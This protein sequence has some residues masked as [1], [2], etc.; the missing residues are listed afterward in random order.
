M[1]EELASYKNH[2][3][4]LEVKSMKSETINDLVTS[5]YQQRQ[6]KRCK[7]ACPDVAKCE[8]STYFRDHAALAYGFIC[9][10][11]LIKDMCSDVPLVKW[12]NINSL[13]E[14]LRNPWQAQRAITQYDVVRKCTNM[15]MRLQYGYH[16]EHYH[17]RRQLMK[18]FYVVS[19]YLNGAHQIAQR[20]HLLEEFYAIIYKREETHLL[21]CKVLR[22][23]TEKAEILLYMLDKTDSLRKLTLI[24]RHD[25]CT[26]FYPNPLWEH[27]CHFLEIA[28]QLGIAYGCFELLIERIKSRRLFYHELCMKCFA[29]LLRCE[30]GQKRF[31]KIDGVKMLYDII[32]DEQHKLDNNE[33]V[34]LA[35]LHGLVSDRVL[36]RCREFTVL[37]KRIIA[38]AKSKNA[39]LQLVCL[40]ILRLLCAMPCV[41]AYILNGCMSD[42]MSIKCLNEQNECTRDSLAEWLNRDIWDSSEM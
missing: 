22:N 16:Q 26:P 25:P 32:A 5:A 38:L 29:M 10:E 24:F 37:P 7:C 15:F 42:I 9:V 2:F 33:Y 35:L 11:K 34:L 8:S 23:L 6:S 19:G 1:W 3:L 36:W 40:K 27:L 31:D 30:E 39:N 28:P 41:K 18:I 13:S 17:E 12:Q 4:Q 20:T 21:A 14:V